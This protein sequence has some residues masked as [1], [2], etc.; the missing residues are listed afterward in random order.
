M[1]DVKVSGEE[2]QILNA[3]SAFNDFLRRKHS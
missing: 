1:D 3:M 2:H